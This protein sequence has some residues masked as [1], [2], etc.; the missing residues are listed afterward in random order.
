MSQQRAARANRPK[1]VSKTKSSPSPVPQKKGSAVMVD[2]DEYPRPGTTAQTLAA[3][4]PA[5]LRTAR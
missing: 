1:G 5:F 3:L 2:T 4:K